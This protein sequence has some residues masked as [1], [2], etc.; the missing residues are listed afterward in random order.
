MQKRPTNRSADMKMQYVPAMS[1]AT[2][3]IPP[4][5]FSSTMHVAPFAFTT[6]MHRRGL[7]LFWCF[8]VLGICLESLYLALSPL[9]AGNDPV[10]DPLFQAWHA[11][12]PGLPLLR[13]TAWLPTQLWLY[14][15]WFNPAT[16][17]GN[18]NLLLL[19]LCLVLLGVLLAAQMGRLQQNMSPRSRRACA[20]LIL[21]FATLFA[22][23][24][25]LSPPHLDIFSRDVLLSWL[26]SRMVV[27]Y[28]VNPYIMAPAA[29]PHDVVTALLARF[30]ADVM[31]LSYSPVSTTGP[32]GIDIGILVSLFGQDQLARI[33]LSFRVVGLLLHLGNALFIWL[34]LHRSK[35]ELGI[36]A[37]V[38]YAWNPLFLLLSVAQMHQEVVTTFFVLLAVYFLRRDANVLSWFF[39]LLA[40]LINFVCLLLLPHFLSII[41]RKTRFLVTRRQILLGLALFSL[42]LVVF[43]LAYFPYWGGGAWN[44]LVRNMALV[45]FP[46]RALNSLDAMLLALPFPTPILKVFNPM[47]W[48]GVLLGFMGLFVLVSFWLA[49]TF[50]GL[51]LCATWLLLIFLIFQPLYWPWYVLLPLTLIL[52]SAHRKTL[53]LGSFLL[54]GALFS[55]YCWSRELNN[56][57]GQANFV[58]GFPCLL[59]GWCILFMAIWE[60]AQR[61]GG[62]LAEA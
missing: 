22:L 43:V 3:M 50:D 38:L 11:F 8:F 9:L 62:E 48:S 39:L 56:W 36:P 49:D 23:T 24:I 26:A 13:W 51:L 33:L 27:I 44:G 55:Y 47:Y 4:S 25:L 57:P 34:V 10:H 52:C 19:V 17:A 54:L 41:M 7:N 61:K 40:V 46:S 60:I 58:L 1:V 53:L 2:S 5:S 37:L 30:P 29:Y 14:L 59:W 35:P 16:L 20:W 6:R 12:L 31:D 18:A 32:V 42:S 45:F 28:H 15:A 21:L